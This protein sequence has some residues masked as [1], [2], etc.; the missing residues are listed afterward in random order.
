MEGREYTWEEL[1]S[2]LDKAIVLRCPLEDHCPPEREKSW[3]TDECLDLIEERRK[4][5][6]R[7]DHK[8]Y[9][10]LCKEVKRV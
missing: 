4:A 1:A 8:R 10:E 6:A 7:G 5:K 3:M 2:A 9:N